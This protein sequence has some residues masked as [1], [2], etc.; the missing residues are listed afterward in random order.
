MRR[1]EVVNE[2]VNGNDEHDH[3]KAVI[4]RTTIEV[5]GSLSVMMATVKRHLPNRVLL[6]DR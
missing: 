4:C 6:Y 2:V 5:G 3:D 1:V